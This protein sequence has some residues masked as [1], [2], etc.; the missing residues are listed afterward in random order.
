MWMGELAESPRIRLRQRQGRGGSV[1]AGAAASGQGQQRQGR[2]GS[3]RAKQGCG[4]MLARS[5]ACWAVIGA[6]KK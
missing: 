3:V 5:Q 4:S 6:E 2:G 1:R